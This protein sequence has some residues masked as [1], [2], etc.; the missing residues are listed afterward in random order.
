LR[1][2]LTVLSTFSPT[3]LSN[4]TI[5]GMLTGASKL[6]PVITNMIKRTPYKNIS[7][8]GKALSKTQIQALEQSK[9]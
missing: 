7:I 4:V 5:D 9:S 6:V 3:N 2:N 8:N 1:N